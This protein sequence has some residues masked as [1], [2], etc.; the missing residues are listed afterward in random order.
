MSR[1]WRPRS[2]ADLVLDP[3]R[4]KRVEDSI[5]LGRIGQP[6][7]AAELIVWLLSDKASLVTGA[8]VHVG[9]GGFFVAGLS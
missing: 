2:G 4:L 3:P 1:R 6:E 8:H 9:G 7:G 5:P